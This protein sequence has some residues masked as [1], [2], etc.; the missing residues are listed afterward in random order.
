MNHLYF[1][2]CLEV[3]KELAAN[4]EPFIDLIYID[5]PFNSKR[6][7]NVLFENINLKDSNA[8]KQAFAD[9]WS[10]VLYIIELNNISEL[11]K[12]L[13]DLLSFFDRCK[14]VNDSAVAYLTTMAVRIWFMHKLLKNTGSFYLHC[15]QTMSHYLK[16]ICDIIF[17][18]KNFQNDIVWKRTFAHSDAK[19]YSRVSDT[20]L[21]Y[22]KT[23]AF[24]FNKIKL[25]YNKDYLDRYYGNTDKTNNK[26]YAL[27][28]LVKPKGSIG[29]F[30]DLC[31]C[32]APPN[33][34]RMPQEKANIW[35]AEGRIAIPKTGKTPRYKRYIDEV[36]GLS[37]TN[38]W[39]DLPPINSQAKEA[40]GYP[41]Q[42]PEA[43][44]ERIINTSTNEETLSLISFA[45]A[46]QV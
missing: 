6:N 17:G 20:I 8:Q 23:A 16:L 44:L 38:I 18:E 35:L 46:A 26:R 13:F 27:D 36:N 21:F 34:W 2:D 28:S 32:A 33:G 22:S 12:D 41:T 29:Y 45:A 30:Y 43:L 9:T 25:G 7:Y 11:N 24:K 40:L 10:N 14:S 37:Q 4:N 19:R 5:P 1:G 3:L 31:G 15:D 42:K 39:T